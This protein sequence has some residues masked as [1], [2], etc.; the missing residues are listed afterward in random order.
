VVAD[1]REVMDNVSR[2]AASW[3]FSKTP[4]ENLAAR[5]WDFST[6]PPRSSSSPPSRSTGAEAFPGPFCFSVSTQSIG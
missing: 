1:V 3:D 5:G 4:Q 2:V 6:T